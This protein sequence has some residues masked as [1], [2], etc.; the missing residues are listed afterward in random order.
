MITKEN[1]EEDILPMFDDQGRF[2]KLYELGNYQIVK[3]YDDMEKDIYYATYVDYESTHYM[4]HNL[5]DAISHCISYR[6][7]KET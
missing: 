3:Y 6:Y 4:F 5:K 1:F 7:K 2:L